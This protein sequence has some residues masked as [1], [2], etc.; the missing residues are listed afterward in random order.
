APRDMVSQCIYKEIR[1]GRGVNGKDHVVLDMTG[2]G[3]EVLEHK[4][5]EIS[6][7]SRVYL[8]IDPVKQPIP[9]APTCH[10]AMGGI[11]TNID[12]QVVRSGD[13][14]DTVEGF[15]AC[16]EAACVS[17][18]GAN[19]LGTNSLLDLV[20][21]GRRTGIEMAK[22]IQAGARHNSMSEKPE[23]ATREMLDGILSRTQGEKAVVI[24]TDLQ[25]TMMRNV[26]VYRT[27]DTLTEA[28]DDLQTLRQ[29][30]ASVT[31]DDKGKRFNTDLMDALEVGF[32][33]D[34]AE[35]ITESARNR[36]ES[37]GAHLRE[38][39]SSREDGEWLKHTLFWS[40]QKGGTEIG[41]KDV[42]ITQFQ[43]KERKY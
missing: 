8:G 19:R 20:V 9:V 13:R 15:F 3:S 27:D 1:E 26:S 40:D 37:R 38:D 4:L 10:Y 7:F 28:M 12:G 17:V 11:P 16:G 2:V 24:R 43:P 21:F 31:C 14:A 34:Y 41:Y 39:Y 30:A 18:H 5:P 35:S 29:R 25:E 32:M 33:V 36:T 22:Q 23:R 42:V 6:T